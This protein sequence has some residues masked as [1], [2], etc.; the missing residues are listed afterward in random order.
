MFP[1]AGLLCIK[2]FLS[3]VFVS[4]SP[5][6][7]FIG[8]TPLINPHKWCVS[9]DLCTYLFTDQLDV[10]IYLYYAGKSSRG[11]GD[12]QRGL[13]RKTVTME[14]HKV[15]D[16]SPATE[17]QCPISWVNQNTHLDI[18]FVSSKG[19]FGAKTRENWVWTCGKSAFIGTG[20]N[21]TVR[22]RSVKYL[23]RVLL[24]SL[25]NQSGKTFVSFTSLFERWTKRDLY[26]LRYAN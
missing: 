18:F 8:E 22:K 6:T 2:L 10:E 16:C 4:L 25:E 19:R 20:K 23:R 21:S 15:L 13:W 7:C 26:P 12:Y 14:Y 9:D 3:I 1:S 24:L 5:N 11:T 17:V